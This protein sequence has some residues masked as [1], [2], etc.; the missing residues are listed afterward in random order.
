MTTVQFSAN[1]QE[2]SLANNIKAVFDAIRL[3]YMPITQ[4][5]HPFYAS[6]SPTLNKKRDITISANSDRSA[7]TIS[8][9]LDNF[10]RVFG[11][12][13]Y[14]LTNTLVEATDKSKAEH[15]ADYCKRI[16]EFLGTDAVNIIKVSS[17]NINPRIEFDITTLTPNIISGINKALQVSGLKP[18]ATTQSPSINFNA[19]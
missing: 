12:S 10:E 11:L 19:A 7:A 18:Y 16:K 15:F 8:I 9:P 3:T 17:H 4:E 1:E 2:Q 5:Y 6:I 13:Y 14:V